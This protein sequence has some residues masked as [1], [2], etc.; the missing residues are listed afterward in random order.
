MTGAGPLASAYQGIEMV[1]AEEAGQEE[2]TDVKTVTADQLKIGWE[3][4]ASEFTDGGWKLSFARQYEQ[5]KWILPE[6][7]ELRKV[8]SVTFHVSGQTV[9][10]SLKVYNGGDDAEAAN[11][12]Y[13]LSGQNAYTIEPS[14]DGSMDAVGIMITDE[15][16][17]DASVILE[18]VT[19]ELKGE[20]SIE[21]NIPDWKDSLTKALGTDMIAG[22]AIMSSEISDDTLMNLVYKHFNA[23]TF[24]NELKPD[25]L[26]NYQLDSSVQTKTVDFKGQELLVPVVNEAGDSLDFSRADQMADKILAWNASHPDDKIRIRGH[27]LVWHSQTQE[28]FF[29]EN[30]DVNQPYVD[31]DTMNRRLEWYISSVFDHYFGE[32]AHGKYDG[33][34]YGWD[35]VNEAVIGNN[36]RT[37]TV[38]ASENLS[39]IRHGNNSSW[40]HVYRSN[41]FIIRAFQYANQ[42]APK[43]VE[44]Y[45]NDFGETD[46]TKSEGIA[47]LLTDVKEAEGTRIDAFGMQAH[48]NVDGFSVKQFK[49]V[50]E[51]YAAIV[52]KVQ[53]TELDFKASNAFDGTDAT[54]NAEYTKMAYCHKQIFD[55][56]KELN[57]NG[58][59]ISGLTVWG[60]IEPNSWL[61]EQSGVGGGADGKSKQCP[62][63]FDGNYKAKPAYWAYVDA[64]KLEPSIQKLIVTE[65]QGDSLNGQTYELAQ[66]DTEA[67]FI[68]VWDANGLTVQIT[69]K[70]T[71]VDDTDAVT[72]YVDPKTSERDA[73]EPIKATVARKDAT[74]TEDGYEAEISVPV[75]DLAIADTIG[76]DVAV[77]NGTERANFNDLTGSQE[78][79]SKYYAQAVMKPGI[80]SVP[81]GTVT[82]DGEWDDAWEQAVT[83]PLTI[84]LGANV[85]ADAKVLWDKENLYVYA[86]VQDPVLNQDNGDAWEQ[87]SVEVFIDENNH[88]SES[89]EEDDK[90]YRISYSNAHSFSGTKCLEENV[91]SKTRV[92]EDGYV[93]EAAFKWTDITP[94]AGRQIG[95]EFQVNDAD[96]NGKRVGTLSWND[97]T[98]MGWSST[99]VYGT[100]QLAEKQPEPEPTPTPEP[101]PMPAPAPT[102]TPAPNPGQTPQVIPETKQEQKQQVKAET[103]QKKAAETTQKKA[104]ETGDNAPVASGILALLLGSVTSVYALKRRGRERK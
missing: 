48:Y 20:E 83:I 41:E 72:V 88:K 46:N 18:S 60:V 40:W 62:L 35:V 4:A 91:T 79:S 25:A 28:W 103:T 44:L 24:G 101:E 76:M 2:K 23:V 61:H 31:K 8:K 59:K 22:T 17:T 43:D 87:D 92:T 77:T 55:V 13:G 51:K 45:Y 69:V 10:I 89:Y 84:N 6:K 64:T 11:T 19:I 68:P 14:G 86:K 70:D 38:S 52:G 90:Q 63:L 58:T 26:F 29:H 81:Y 94:E 66:G 65:K 67:S 93:V 33:L 3:N 34:F 42:Y 7:I 74:K 56:A 9:P 96:V 80:A 27:V 36:Y 12:Q 82:I 39:E 32:E 54:K 53:L 1:Y 85:S 98:G 49:A 30:Y 99:A 16:P 97:E 21:Q 15:N 102:P 50:A 104:A 95:L 57:Q 71:T 100:V 75:S 73:F 5:V 47:K 37:D 78:T